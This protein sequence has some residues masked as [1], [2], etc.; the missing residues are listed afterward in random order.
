MESKV[1]GIRGAIQVSEDSVESVL[2]ATRRLLETMLE[3]NEVATDD[4]ISAIFTTT[5]DLRS[6]FPAEAARSLGFS[7]TPLICA[8]EIDVPG[9]LP[10]VVRVLLWVYS[11]KGKSAIKHVYLDGAEV[12]RKDIAQ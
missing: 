5:P 11:G 4:A 2:N 7:D 10:R 12:L 1:R 8:Q 3:L 6:C 9:S